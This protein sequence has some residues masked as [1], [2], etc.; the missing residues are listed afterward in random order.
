MPV[1]SISVVNR[2]ATS[3]A[4]I[5]ASIRPAPISSA[6][7]ATPMT[8]SAPADPPTSS[9]ICLS[10]AISAAL[11]VRSR[12]T[13]ASTRGTPSSGTSSRSVRS[14]TSRDSD[15]V[16]GVSM[17][18]VS[19]SSA[20]GHSTSRS[21]DVLGIEA[22]EVE[23]QPAVT[24]DRHIGPPAAAVVGGHLRRG[25]VPEPGHDAGGLGGVGGRNVL[26]DKRIDQRGLAG[27]Q[28][29]GQ[30]DADRLVEP[31]TDPLQLV[32]H[33]G[34]MPVRRIVPVGLDG[35]AQDR[36]HLIARAQPSRLPCCRLLTAPGE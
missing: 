6:R 12:N 36:A 16:P 14:E 24:G 29:A 25:A 23:R 17:M 5:I 28:R 20:A 26:A 15:D 32:V 9:P 19:I 3:L 31:A 2:L 11:S 13:T 4:D 33:V 10:S 27:L 8:P 18:V 35:A 34:P 7:E 22:G 30:R 21:S 1:L